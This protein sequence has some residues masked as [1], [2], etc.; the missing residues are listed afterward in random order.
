MAGMRD[1]CIHAYFAVTCK[2]V[3]EA[4]KNEISPIEPLIAS[5][6]D[7]LRKQTNPSPGNYTDKQ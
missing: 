6:P 7:D 1:K 3:W 2:T 4:V 5:F